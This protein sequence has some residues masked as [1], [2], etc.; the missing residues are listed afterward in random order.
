MEKI[1]SVEQQT[2]DSVSRFL[3]KHPIYIFNAARVHL[4]AGDILNT[5]KV[6]SDLYRRLFNGAV[7]AGNHIAESST[8]KTKSPG[9]P[10][11][12]INETSSTSEINGAQMPL[13]HCISPSKGL[14]LESKKFYYKD[15]SI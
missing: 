1:N 7:C 5:T 2:L 12:Y 11:I 6:L 14:I 15:L 10:K 9:V 4:L 3:S 8:N 13:L